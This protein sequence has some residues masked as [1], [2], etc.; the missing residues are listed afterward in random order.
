MSKKTLIY[1]YEKE[2]APKGGPVGYN[3]NLKCQLD[4]M[5]VDGISFIKTNKGDV[6][7]LTN[8]INKIRP[9]WLKKT[10]QTIKR[11]ANYYLL[12]FGGKGKAVVDLDKYDI[13]HFHSVVSMYRCRG[14]LEHYKGQVVLTSHIPTKA[15]KE[16]EMRLN[17]FEKVAFHWLYKNLGKMDVYAF[18]RAD[19]IVFPCEGAEEPYLNNW[20]YYKDFKEKNKKKYHY[21][22]TGINPCVAK[23][24][25]A[26]IRDRYKIPKDAFIICFVG[27]HNLIKGYDQLKEIGEELLKY[28]DVYVLIAGEEGPLYHLEHE[29]WIEVGWTNDPHSIIA[30]SDV[31]VLPNKETYFD[32][33][34]LEV[35]S[36]GKLIVASNTGGNKYFSNFNECGILL[37]NSKE[38]A[39]SL[40]KKIK[41]L[42]SEERE[43]LGEANR[44]MFGE[45]FTS[46][47]FAKNYIKLINS[48]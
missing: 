26:L 46:E 2:L 19:H 34:M 12:L 17:T 5:G 11:I 21:L 4:K 3:Y 37:Y 36:L 27:R 6:H 16:I 42:T 8:N 47:I 1:L 45:Y 13:V 23:T 18:N 48:L 40:I 14:S 38:E 9:L 35:L 32:L 25:K 43:K 39:V 28:Q 15:T 20:P 33:I 7:E 10:I 31:F 41:D 29:R 44:K 30:A 22:L 24:S